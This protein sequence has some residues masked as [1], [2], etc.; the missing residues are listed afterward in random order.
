MPPDRPWRVQHDRLN[1]ETQ[2]T[3]TFRRTRKH[4][5]GFCDQVYLHIPYDTMR[6]LN[7]LRPDVVLS[8]ELGARTVQ[9]LIYRLLHPASRLV[10]SL[11]LS[12]HTEKGRGAAR[13]VL[14]RV[15]LPFADA[16]LVNGTSAMRYVRRFGVA[17][18]KIFVVPQASDHRLF[19]RL[20]LGKSSDEVR[21]LTYV[22]RLIELKGLLPFL[23]VLSR[24]CGA[25]TNDRVQFS[26]VGDGPERGSLQTAVLPPNLELRFLG[27]VAYEDLPGLYARAGILVF[28]TLGDEWGIVV[29]EAM[30]AGLPVLGSVYSQAVDELVED[31]VTG[32]TFQP[33]QADEIYAALD[34]A[35]TASEDEL[36]QMGMAAR[37]AVEHLTPEFVADGI[38]DAIHFTLHARRD[39]KRHT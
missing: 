6:R 31:G 20:P 17:D 26:L 28:P 19:F 1:V 29:N 37:R 24:W 14:R 15:L 25:H 21:H 11:G 16:V 32:W 36:R 12:E 35:L 22:G 13:H 9:A 33:N 39:R 10:I 38:M 7:S 23:S 2:K 4:P 8:S 27:N 30:A 18:R 5:S 34:R 3:L